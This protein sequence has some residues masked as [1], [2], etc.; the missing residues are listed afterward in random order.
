MAK[1]TYEVLVKLPNG[2]MQKI[3]VQADNPLNA[4]AMIEAQY[5]KKARLSPAMEVR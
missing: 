5:G 4:A 2:S 1:K 3:A